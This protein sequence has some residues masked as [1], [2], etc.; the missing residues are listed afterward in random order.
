LLTIAIPVSHDTGGAETPNVSTAL[1]ATGSV[2]V[3]RNCYIAEDQIPSK[4]SISELKRLYN[5]DTTPDSTAI[6]TLP[7][8]FQPPEFIQAKTEPTAMQ[9]GS[10]MHTAIEHL[11]FTNFEIDEYIADLQR[12]N[13]LSEQDAALV[14]RTWLKTL[15]NS[16]LADRMRKSTKIYRETPF[17]MKLSAAELYPNSQDEEVLVHGIVDCFFEENGELVLVDYK[18]D[19]NPTRHTTQMAIYK[20]AIENSMAMK[21]KE[22]LIYSFALGKAIPLTASNA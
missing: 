10:A 21:V 8:I 1:E 4:L 3:K 16:N 7:P 11:D 6:D 22:V 20:K 9:L 5:Y 15:I 12:R 13:L 2:D 14:N 17:V 19:G 18:S